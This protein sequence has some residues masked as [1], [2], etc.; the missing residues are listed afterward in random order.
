LIE[1]YMDIDLLLKEVG[2]KTRD[3]SSD[4]LEIEAAMQP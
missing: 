3:I 4:R 1:T 2:A